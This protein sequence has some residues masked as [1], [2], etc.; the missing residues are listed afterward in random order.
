MVLSSALLPGQLATCPIEIYKLTIHIISVIQQRLLAD[1]THSR[2]KHHP[3]P[4]SY[5][6]VDACKSYKSTRTGH[7]ARISLVGFFGSNHNAEPL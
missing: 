7:E 6:K 3:R 5:L 2:S 1:H 4:Q